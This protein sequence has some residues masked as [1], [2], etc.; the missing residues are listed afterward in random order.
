MLIYLQMLDTPE[1]KAKFE[2][3][4]YSHRRTMLHIAMKILKDAAQKQPVA[5]EGETATF[6]VRA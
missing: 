4:Y 2:T 1:E 6:D 3:L 5:C